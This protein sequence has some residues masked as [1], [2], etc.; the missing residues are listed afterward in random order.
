MQKVYLNFNNNDYN[1]KIN[2]KSNYK[3]CLT[4][5]NNLFNFVL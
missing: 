1:Y 4:L 2:T 3:L 5:E